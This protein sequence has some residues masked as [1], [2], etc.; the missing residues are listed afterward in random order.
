ML[1]TALFRF[2][3]LAA[4]AFASHAAAAQP[5]DSWNSVRSKNFSIV[6]STTVANLQAAAARL[7]QFRWAFSR[8]YPQFNLDNDQ[9]TK[10]VIF[11]DAASYFE[12]LPKRLDGSTDVGV[13]GYFQP[14]EDVDYITLAIP[15]D[16]ID[17]LSTAVH[18]YFHSLL[19]SNFDRSQLPPWAN[20]GLAEYFETVHVENGRNIVVGAQQIEHLRMLRRSAFIP[21]AEFFAITAADLKAMSPERRRLYYAEA[22][23]VVHTMVQNGQLSMDKLA[24]DLAHWNESADEL[25]QERAR[26]QQDLNRNVRGAFPQPRSVVASDAMP[27]PDLPQPRALSAAQVSMTLGDLLLHTGDSARGDLFLRQAVAADHDDPNANGSLGVLLMREDRTAEAK[28]FLQKAVATGNVNPVVLFYHAYAL[29]H[30]YM[31]GSSIEELTDDAAQVIRISLRR[32]I[33]TG[34]TFTESYRLLA[35]VDF[36]RDEQLDDAVALLQKGLTIKRDDPE[37]QLLLARIL[38]RREDVGRAKQ[39]AEQIASTTSDKKRKAEADEIVKAVYDYNAAKTASAVPVRLNITVGDRQGLVILKRSW[40][41][42]DD[43]AK[44]ERERE[45]NNYNRIIIRPV[46]GEQSVVGRIEKIA[47]SGALITYRVRTSD[48]TIN[49]TSPDFNGIRMTVARE[50]ERTFQVGCGADISKELAVVNYRP[51]AAIN[52]AKT[53]GELTAISFV[54]DDFRLKSIV[55]MNA[56]RLVAIDD[57]TLR[58]SGEKP[59]ITPTSIR[60]SIE[61]YLRKAARD[62]ARV[63]GTIRLIECSTTEIDFHVQTGDKILTFAHGVPGT[64]EMGWFTVASSQLPVACGSG[65]LAANAIFTFTRSTR[66]A[67]VDGELKS[68]EF[69]PDKFEP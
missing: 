34:P 10:I 16:Q 3:T 21:L 12:F 45:N 33:E 61:Q 66:F 5:A 2:L 9:R 19:E 17:P 55:E 40:L 69:V 68:I 51:R 44:I 38:L 26:L 22:W 25:S 39:I 63:L 29:L 20:E 67:N 48:T 28:P 49:L 37:M 46:T 52:A 6:G 65:P 43:I 23:A 60:R 64:V 7:E 14:G 30:E 53:E 13:A 58:R 35:L 47:C 54:A 1:R 32:A 4:F 59:S 11:K 62:E 8:L 50:G 36:V 56:A 42:D 15:A 24:D 18:E 27:V 57:D 41:N 31:K